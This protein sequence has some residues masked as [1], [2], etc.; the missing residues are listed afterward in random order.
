MD[1]KTYCVIAI[2]SCAILGLTMSKD[3]DIFK[4]VNVR[5]MGR[6]MVP[7]VKENNSLATQKK[8]LVIFSLFYPYFVNKFLFF[9]SP[10]YV[11]TLNLVTP[12]QIQPFLI[13]KTAMM[14][15]SS[16]I[17]GAPCRYTDSFL[18]HWSAVWGPLIAWLCYIKSC[19]CKTNNSRKNVENRVY[20]V[21]NV[22]MSRDVQYFVSGRYMNYQKFWYTHCDKSVC[23]YSRVLIYTIEALNTGKR[24]AGVSRLCIGNQCRRK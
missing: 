3:I 6:L 20:Y 21:G 24:A 17:A 14:Q 2:H 13:I 11:N 18:R 9:F 23:R 5:R 10:C 15:D 16:M 4:N 8:V 1:I 22:F 7:S 19:L 12:A